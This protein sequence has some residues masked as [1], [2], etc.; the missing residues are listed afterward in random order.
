MKENKGKDVS[1]GKRPKTQPQDQPK[2]QTQGRPTAGDKRKSL[3]KNLDLEGVPSRR[4]KRAKHSSSKVVKFKPAQFQP[5]IQVVDVD[6]STPIES[7]PSKSPS[8]KIPSSK[9]TTS[10]SSQPSEKTSK[11]IVENEDLAWE[12]FQMAVLDK[13]INACY[14]MGLKEFE[15]SSVHDPFKVRP[16]SILILVYLTI[17]LRLT[18]PLFFI[19]HVKVYG[20]VQTCNG[21]GQEEDSVRDKDLRGEC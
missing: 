4:D 14:D 20:G 9:S 2:V 17:F 7:N 12:R 19:S 5:P 18:I 8:S 13:D 3:P 11:N 21:T 10:G 1:E 15:H 16:Y 6:S